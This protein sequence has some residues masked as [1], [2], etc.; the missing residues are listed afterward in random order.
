[1]VAILDPRIR[2][3][4]YGKRF[5]NALPSCPTVGDLSSVAEFFAEDLRATA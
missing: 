1:V 2:T 5:L 4:A 3:R